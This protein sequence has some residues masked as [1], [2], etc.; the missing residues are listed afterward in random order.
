M[1]R[2]VSHCWFTKEE[3]IIDKHM[4]TKILIANQFISHAAFISILPFAG[5]T[6]NCL[7]CYLLVAESFQSLDDVVGN[8]EYFLQS[9]VLM[10]FNRD[11]IEILFSLSA[12][13]KAKLKRNQDSSSQVDSSAVD[14]L[15]AS[16]Y[17]TSTCA[18][19]STDIWS[20]SS[21]VL[22]VSNIQLRRGVNRAI[23]NAE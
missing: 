17:S 11:G 15:L 23:F 1:K 13:S 9:W 10:A 4:D 12:P 19:A 8:S 5:L 21:P 6:I 20:C 14:G 18:F 3:S 16:T 7:G 22:V 2:C